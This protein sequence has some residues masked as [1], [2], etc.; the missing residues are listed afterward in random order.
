VENEVNL[1]GLTDTAYILEAAHC[2]SRLMGL[3]VTCVVMAMGFAHHYGQVP[4]I[5]GCLYLDKSQRFKLD[6]AKP[7]AP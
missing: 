2:C 6:L 4:P 7:I 1:R 3:S 5:I